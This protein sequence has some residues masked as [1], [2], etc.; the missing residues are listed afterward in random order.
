M[1]SSDADPVAYLKIKEH[2]NEEHKNADFN[3]NTYTHLEYDF[4]RKDTK[5]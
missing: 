3:A 5:K 1:A 2:K 4:L